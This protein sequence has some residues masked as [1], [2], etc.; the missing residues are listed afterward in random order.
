MTDLPFEGEGTDVGNPSGYIAWTLDVGLSGRAGLAEFRN[1]G[2][3]ITDAVWYRLRG[4]IS[5][6]LMRTDN[7][8]SADPN[9]VISPAELGEWS[10]G[11][12]GRFAYQVVIQQVDQDTGLLSAAQYTVLSDDPLSKQEAEA[13]AMA[14]FGDPENEARYGQSVVGA[15]AIHGWATVPWVA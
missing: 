2:G 11:Q 5:D 13:Q 10:A 14:D 7:F 9:A 3:R 12:G 1:D 8:L 4:Q 6:T 15:F